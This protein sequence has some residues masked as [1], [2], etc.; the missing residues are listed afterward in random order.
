MKNYYFSI[1]NTTDTLTNARNVLE[2]AHI[3]HEMIPKPTGLGAGCGIA[4]KYRKEDSRI[5]R[6][7]LKEKSIKAIGTYPFP[8]PQ[9]A[10]I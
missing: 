8:Y 3:E 6:S 5:V 9:S 4:L 2:D 1:F 10:L 7:M